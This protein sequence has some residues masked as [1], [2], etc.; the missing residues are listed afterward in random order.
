[1]KNQS[2]RNIISLIHIEIDQT[3][4]YLTDRKLKLLFPY[5]HFF[6][7]LRS[8]VTASTLGSFR[9]H[10]GHLSQINSMPKFEALNKPSVYFL[11]RFT[12]EKLSLLF[13]IA[14]E[15]DYRA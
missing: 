9:H 2:D 11:K 6:P 14:N 3:D 13:L 4:S 8:L 7:N 15:C 5:R 1:M 12:E 10:K